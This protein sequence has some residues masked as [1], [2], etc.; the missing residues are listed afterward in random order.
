MLVNKLFIQNLRNHSEST[1]EFVRG[2]NI[3]Y[4]NNGAGKTTILEAVSIASITKSFLP[5][6]DSTLVKNGHNEYSIKLLAENDINLNYSV[7]IDYRING[8][9]S[10]S[11]NSDS[12]LLPKDIIGN[13]PVVI[14]S[15]DFKSI[16]FGSPQNRRSFIDSILCQSSKLYM[17]NLLKIRRCVKQRNNLLTK[18][19]KE[20]NSER[21]ELE[22]WTNLLIELSAEIVV[23][24][25][26][27]VDEFIPYFTK[28]CKILGGIAESSSICYD[29]N[30]IDIDTI[31][32]GKQA[33]KEHFLE[34]TEKVVER[35]IHRGTTLFGP[36][37]DDLKIFVNGGIAKDY[38]SQGQH[39]SLLISLKF[40]EFEYL[41]DIRNETPIILLDDIFSELDNQRT[42]KVL[43][44]VN[45]RKAQ[46]IITLTNPDRIVSL[47]KGFESNSV[48]EVVSGNILL[49]NR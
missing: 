11:T 25:M 18:L 17:D 30:S 15:P 45:S 3:I 46:T 21:S 43:N 34:L 37:R 13:M 47:S 4:G 9:K 12:N 33:A 29:P 35:E 44:L 36:Q 5:A 1:I 32:Q 2:L 23:K 22:N 10:I 41:K 39:K 7:N 6:P 48:F 49:K 24:R 28:H 26:K 40:A 8:K 42:E 27:F 19:K 31:K 38:A 20:R 16:T 14:L